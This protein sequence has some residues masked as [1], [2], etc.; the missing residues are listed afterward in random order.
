MT[1]TFANPDDPQTIVNI[2]IVAIL[3]CCA[4]LAA[5]NTI[6][7]LSLDKDDIRIKSE[8]GTMDEKK[9][10]KRVYPLISNYHL[11]MVVLML[12]NAGANEAL[13]IFLGKLVPEWVAIVIAVILVLMI[14]EIIPSAVL[15]GPNQLKYAYYMAPLIYTVRIVLF[16]PSYPIARFLDWLLPEAE[17]RRLHR[18]IIAAQLVE[19]VNEEIVYDHNDIQHDR[20]IASTN[21]I[22][23]ITSDEC[24]ILLAV[25]RSRSINV[26]TIMTPRANVFKVSTTMTL[27]EL[28]TQMHNHGYSRVLVCN[29]MD[30]PIGYIHMRN[31]LIVSDNDMRTIADIDIDKYVVL[32]SDMRILDAKNQ[33]IMRKSHFAIVND[34]M[35]QFVGIVT[36]EDTL[37][38][39]IGQEISDEGDRADETYALGV[40]R[41]FFANT[42]KPKQPVSVL[43]IH[44]GDQSV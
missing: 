31:L 39:I 2:I 9:Y 7:M 40:L 13:P 24:K 20:S 38:H 29:D 1:E 12:F 14:G 23:G 19:Q 17:S 21:T 42:R 6:G 37:E 34:Q 8:N 27:V 35:G 15:S 33:F 22:G 36:L 28:K 16:L 3:I 18:R 26:G 4:G 44:T 5:G 30:M 43:A 32:E 10:A 41:T 25:L 11:L